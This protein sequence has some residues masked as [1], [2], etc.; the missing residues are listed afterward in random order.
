[1]LPAKYFSFLQ[2]QVAEAA[3]AAVAQK[4]RDAAA[5]LAAQKEREAEAARIQVKRVLF[6]IHLM[7]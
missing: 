6:V 1:M 4:K 7:F 5:A 2:L 3:E